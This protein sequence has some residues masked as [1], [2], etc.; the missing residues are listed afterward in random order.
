MLEA[1]HEHGIVHRDLKPANIMVRSDGAV[2]V[3]DFG[4]AKSLDPVAASSAA[5]ANSPTV[6]S[7]AMTARGVIVGTAA[8]M[9]PEQ[10]R[11]IAV[12]KRA[13]LPANRAMKLMSLSIST[14]PEFL[15]GVP[16][17]VFESA[18]LAIAWGRSYDVF[19]RWTAVP[20]RA[21]E[22]AVNQPG[23]GSD[24]LRTELV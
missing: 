22:G 20:D 15:A 13:D 2:K 12:D 4:L 7:P 3:L 23:A 18:D 1:A 11:G 16:Q 19:G 8:Y 9:A 24:D 6:T 5:Y 10:A 17:T 21:H 14:A